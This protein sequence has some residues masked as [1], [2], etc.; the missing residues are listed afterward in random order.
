MSESIRELDAGSFD[1]AV[2]APGVAVVDFWAPWCGPCRSMAPVFESAANAMSGQA[3][4]CKVN[5]DEAPAVA[6]RLGI[7]SIPTLVVF[8]DGRPAETLVG[9]Q[10]PADF[11]AAVRRHLP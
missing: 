2:A 9:L 3:R 4:F 7:R 8:R 1:A 6:A 5:V 11:L 10:R